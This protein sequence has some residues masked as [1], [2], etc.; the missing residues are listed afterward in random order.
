MHELHVPIGTYS[1]LA[2][3]PAAPLLTTAEAKAHL[4]V[5]FADDDALIDAYVGAA[6]DML[7]ARFG[8]LGRALITQTWA[9]IMP[10]FPASGHFDLPV[11]PVQSVTAITYFDTDNVQQTLAASTYRVTVKDEAARVDLVEG[12]S[13]PAL[14]D[15]HDVVR[16]EY[17]TG[18]GDAG[19]AVPDGIR[20]AARLMVGHW[21]EN[22]EAVAT[23]SLPTELPLAVA[24][25]LAKYRVTRGHI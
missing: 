24:A 5:D 23:G 13:W 2:V 14:F 19:S 9:L 3:P 4:R 11:P 10:R 20:H 21:Y 17:V 8:E 12:Q 1:R 6:N 22:R 18:Y 15:R 16:V 25:L 7:D